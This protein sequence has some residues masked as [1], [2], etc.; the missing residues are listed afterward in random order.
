MTIRNLLVPV[1]GMASDEAAVDIALLVA[2]RFDAHVD[3]LH[4]QREARA[5]IPLGEDSSTLHAE[6]VKQTQR[7]IEGETR[8]ART[9][10]ER[11]LADAGVEPR[12]GQELL[13][14][15]SA[16]W[17]VAT[18]LE[19]Q[20]VARRGMAYD[21]IVL[22]LEAARDQETSRETLEAALFN[23]GRPVL[24]APPDLPKLPGETVFVAWNRSV[25]SSRAVFS[26]LF[27]LRRARRVVLFTV[28]TGA[29]NGAS[30]EEVGRTLALHGVTCEIREIAPDGRRI[31]QML[32]EEARDVGADLIVMGAYSHSRWRELLLGGV[33][34]YV[35]EHAELPVLMAH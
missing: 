2:R 14:A 13:A 3:G 26:S 28:S 4:V 10:F 8:E 19:A 9:R 27:F 24:L 20:E 29:K 7:F 32:L 35:V 6:L 11:L 16:S 22:G 1:S 5:D 15:P 21:L 18:G 31:G 33:T 23:T 30:A 17:H 25:Q 12:D 34:K